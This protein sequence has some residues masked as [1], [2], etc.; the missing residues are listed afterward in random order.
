MSLILYGVPLSPFYRK[1]EMVLRE[2]GVEFKAETVNIL[3][4][5]DWFKEISPT[6]RIP[7]LRDTAVLGNS[8]L[9][10]GRRQKEQ[11][12][13][14]GEDGTAHEEVPR[15]LLGELGSEDERLGEA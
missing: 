4:L 11:P 8:P 13:D 6:G 5:H 12:R 15:L 14:E 9:P 2:K 7:V 1:A 3:A 10:V